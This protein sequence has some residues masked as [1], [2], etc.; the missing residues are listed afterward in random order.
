[1]HDRSR[2]SCLEDGFNREGEAPTE[3]HIARGLPT[4]A[5]TLLADPDL[6]SDQRQPIPRATH[7]AA[8]PAAPKRCPDNLPPDSHTHDTCRPNNTSGAGPSASFRQKHT[9]SKCRSAPRGLPSSAA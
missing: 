5:L 6:L 1:P 8:S 4:T 3:T 9:P 2:T 7:V